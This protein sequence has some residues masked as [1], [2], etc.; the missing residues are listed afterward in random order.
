VGRQRVKQQRLRV[1]GRGRASIERVGLVQISDGELGYEGGLVTR[2]QTKDERE[3]TSKL[4]I[5]WTG[6]CS[7]DPSLSASPS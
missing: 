2:R 5:G 4:T 1:R 7:L 6:V 3:E